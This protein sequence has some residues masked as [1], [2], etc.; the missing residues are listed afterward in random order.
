M[1]AALQVSPPTPLRARQA[2]RADEAGRVLERLARLRT[3]AAALEAGSDVAV[4]AG[5]A[6]LSRA[7]VVELRAALADD[8]DY[9]AESVDEIV[10][11]GA[12]G[13]IGLDEMGSELLSNLGNTQSLPALALA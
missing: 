3:A 12:V 8:P 9:L 11:R 1:D 13:E 10:M 4:V 7:C 2:R 6:G 5:I